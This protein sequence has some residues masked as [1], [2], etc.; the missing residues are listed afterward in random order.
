M[1]R[2]V[3]WL[4][5]G[6]A[7]VALTL[8]IFMPATWMAMIVEAQTRG[9]LTLGD[10]QGT[11][12]RGSAF[13]GG[14][15]SGADPVTP[16]LPGRFSWRFSPL[17]LLGQ[18]DVD[19]ENPEALSQPL[20]LT[21]SWNQLHLSPSSV[22]LPAERLAGLGAPLNTIQP[23]GRMRLS[24]TPLQLARQ[25]NTMQVNGS[26]TLQMDDIA[27]RLSPIKPLGAY[28]L[29]MDWRG[30]QAQL[31]LTTIK[32]PMLLN[33]SGMLANGRLQFSG[34][35]EAEA[36]QEDRLANLLNLLG[37]RRREGDKDVIALEFK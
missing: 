1:R 10:A 27:S 36:G 12:W 14:A 18:V 25:G 20:K 24:W 23:S 32:G 16:L 6:I 7:S 9:R 3:I 15:P 2:L 19:L 29:I 5:A 26:M 8:M 11:L 28:Q 22:L 31:A 37:Q 13:I 21:G 35:A 33:G 17:V 4:L 30:T 34:K